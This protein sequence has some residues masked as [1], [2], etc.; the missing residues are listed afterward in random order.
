MM[1]V[2]DVLTSVIV[3]PDSIPRSFTIDHDLGILNLFSRLGQSYLVTEYHA[4]L[5]LKP[6]F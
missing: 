6:H 4:C 3:D 1:L 2:M 5:K